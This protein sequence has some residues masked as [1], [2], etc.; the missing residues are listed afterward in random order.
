MLQNVC[1]YCCVRDRY[2]S[3]SPGDK[4]RDHYDPDK[5]ASGPARQSQLHTH[6]TTILC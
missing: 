6:D 2:S 4:I 3:A 5:G 1:L